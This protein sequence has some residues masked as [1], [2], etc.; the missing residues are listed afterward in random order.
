L[1][2]N[3]TV[4]DFREIA[5]VT[6]VSIVV[7]LVIAFATNRHWLHRIAKRYGISRKFGHLDV[8]VYAFDS[9][10]VR[11]ATIRDLQHNFMFTGYVRAF[12]DVET[13]AELVLTDVIAYNEATG[14]KLYEAD[15]MYLSRKKDDITIE[16]PR[17]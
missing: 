10:D 13:N 15:R 7:A 6:V 11:W 8:W 16:F 17:V 3:K 2:E 9:P 14:A 5:G 12:S 4:L 1:T